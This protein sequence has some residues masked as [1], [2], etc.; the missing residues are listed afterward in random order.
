MNA[1]L[2]PLQLTALLAVAGCFGGGKATI[3]GNPAGMSVEARVDDPSRSAQTPLAFAAAVV[4]A[5][6][7]RGEDD[8]SPGVMFDAAAGDVPFV[9]LDLTET[10]REIW[11]GE[12]PPRHLG[13]YTHVRI[14]VP[15]VGQAITYVDPLAGPAE[16]TYVE[17]IEAVDNSDGAV[18][19][20]PAAPIARGDVL[21][22]VDDPPSLQ[23]F[24]I[25]AAREFSSSAV[26]SEVD[27]YQDPDPG[28]ATQVIALDEELELV[29][30]GEYVLS[31]TF[32]VRDTFEYDDRDGDGAF[33]PFGDDH[34]G[35][36]NGIGFRVLVPG[37]SVSAR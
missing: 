36:T 12:I 18:A 25:D 27:A 6:L 33:E 26:R 21:V 30:D 8:P 7:L 24:E 3:T 32:D 23:W 35:T 9:L 15:A 13:T 31:A 19:E 4:K 1:R 37:V 14:T 34:D 10:D 22:A 29:S 2:R 20:L 5:E 16:Q 17:F 28:L 11:A